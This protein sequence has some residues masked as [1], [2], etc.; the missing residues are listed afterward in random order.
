ML[1]NRKFLDRRLDDGATPD[2]RAGVLKNGLKDADAVR[3]RIAN[4]GRGA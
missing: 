3:N 2:G 4:L 1:P